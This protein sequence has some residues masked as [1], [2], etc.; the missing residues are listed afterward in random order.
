MWAVVAV[1]LAVTLAVA[2]R[3]KP[4]GVEIAAVTRGSLIVSVNEDGRTRVKDRYVI[5]APLAG[6]I[7]RM[8]LKAGDSVEEGAVVARLAPSV[9]PLLDQIGRAHV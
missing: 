4:A 6:T 8:T 5:S 3:P 2:L 9:S 1:G 7:T